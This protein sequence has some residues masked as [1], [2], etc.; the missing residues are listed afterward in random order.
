MR[1]P[2]GKPAQVTAWDYEETSCCA[3]EFGFVYYYN[4]NLLADFKQENDII[5]F[6]T[7]W[8]GKM[9]EHGWKG[10]E[11]EAVVVH[12]GDACDGRQ[13]RVFQEIRII[14]CGTWKDSSVTPRFLAG[15]IA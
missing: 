4:R 5:T 12:R 13:E 3:K 11:T 6:L 7:D 14:V 9:M 10:N 15:G 8:S 2:S 1:R